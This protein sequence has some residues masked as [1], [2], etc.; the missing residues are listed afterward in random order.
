MNKETLNYRFL[1]RV[2]PPVWWIRAE[3]STVSTAQRGFKAPISEDL[4]L[5]IDLKFSRS[6]ADFT[7]LIHGTTYTVRDVQRNSMC[8][9]SLVWHP[10]GPPYSCR[11]SITYAPGNP[12]VT[13]ALAAPAHLKQ[14]ASSGCAKIASP[15]STGAKSRRAHLHLASGLAP[16]L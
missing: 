14:G 16:F 13:A 11:R 6:Q 5:S 9:Y 4:I 3:Q 15:T 7:Y 10:R 2:Y 8:T 1:H 12:I